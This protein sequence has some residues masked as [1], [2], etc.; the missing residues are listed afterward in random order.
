[1]KIFF[2]LVVLAFSFVFPVSAQNYKVEAI[3][4]P[5]PGLPAAYAAAIQAQG[6]RVSGPSG[7]W[8]EVWPAKAV[9]AGGKPS[10]AAITFSMPQGSLVGILRF[11][12][13]GSDRRGQV[14]QA[15]VYT[16]RYS[17]FPADGAHQGAAPQRDFALLTPVASDADPA[18]KPDFATL[19][20][21]SIKASGTNHPAVFSLESPPSGAAVGSIAKE[22]ENDWTLT[23]KAGDLTFSVILV[24]RAE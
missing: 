5:A 10:D 8:C 2:L 4:T 18:A 14:I 19:V 9:P 1:M 15:G 3:S 7:V 13:K 16:M 6:Y 22:G 23:L 11:P 12:A 20:Q 24:G 21:W 17:N